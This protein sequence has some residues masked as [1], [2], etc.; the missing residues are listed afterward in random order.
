MPEPVYGE[1]R[2]FWQHPDFP[3][4][5]CNKALGWGKG[6]HDV[7]C[8]RCHRRCAFLNPNSFPPNGLTG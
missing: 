6:A 8:P 1:Y 4:R 3:N 7:V 5:P 2:C